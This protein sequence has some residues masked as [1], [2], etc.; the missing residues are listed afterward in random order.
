MDGTLQGVLIVIAIIAVIGG[1]V[2]LIVRNYNSARYRKRNEEVLGYVQAKGYEFY[3][4][5]VNDL[6]KLKQIAPGYQPDVAGTQSKKDQTLQQ[7]MRIYGIVEGYVEDLVMP[8]GD[9]IWVH[10]LFVIPRDDG[11]QHLFDY[12]YRY[13]IRGEG[14]SRTY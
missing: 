13:I 14:P 11:L 10:N 7:D 9:K 4:G 1:G 12:V 6:G 3:G 2:P 8:S 5:T